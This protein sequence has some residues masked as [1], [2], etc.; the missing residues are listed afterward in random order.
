MLVQ[1]FRFK[2]DIVMIVENEKALGN[3]LTKMNDSCKEYKTKINK[4]KTKILIYNKQAVI[5]SITNKN[6]SM[7][8]IFKKQNNV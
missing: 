2:N 1:I 5:P 7:F 6:Y 3:M 8:Y 4:N